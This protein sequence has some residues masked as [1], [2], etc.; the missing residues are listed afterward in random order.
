MVA[1]FT[2]GGRHPKTQARVRLF[3]V[4]SPAR[5]FANG[6]QGAWYDPSD[7]S[8]L[9]QDSA[10]TTPVASD[11]DP[12]G[13]MEDK[14]GN[15]NHATQAT[16]AARPVYRT[17]GTLH[18]LEF[19]GVDDFLEA[20]SVDLTAYS[21]VFVSLAANRKTSGSRQYALSFRDEDVN[22]FAARI[23]TGNSE[24]IFQSR[25]D[26]AGPALAAASNGADPEKRVQSGLA[27]INEPTVSLRLN[28]AQVSSSADSQGTGT[29]GV[30]PLTIGDDGKGTGYIDAD[31]FGLIVVLPQ[32]TINSIE[33][34]EQYLAQKSGV[35]L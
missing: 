26:S 28:G 15:G 32:S 1:P 6:E 9:Y 24:Y 30:G 12:V 31:L 19:D 23:S 25:A 27:D 2:E 33:S 10:A 4:F 21:T 14:S 5:L 3:N 13:R 11:G 22:S 34:A 20:A 17:D 35:T 8:T 18:W 16:S 7:L 29:Y